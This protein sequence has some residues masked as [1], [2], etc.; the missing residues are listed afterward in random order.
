MRYRAYEHTH[1]PDIVNDVFDSKVYRSLL[2]KPVVV[3]GKE[4]PHKHFADARDV[5]LG[6]STDGFAPFRRRKKTCWPLIL[7]NYNLPP[8]IRF[9][10]HNI[11]SLGVIPGPK[12]PIDLDS[13]LWPAVIEFLRLEL[14]VHAYDILSDE[15]FILRA[16]LI[17]VFGDIPA[18]SLVMQM[19]GH[20]GFRP[21]RM[22]NIHGVRIP[23]ARQPTH[24]VPLDRSQYPASANRANYDPSRLPCRTHDEFLQQANEVQFAPTEAAADRLAQ[25]YGIK[26]TPLLTALSSLSFPDS[27]PYDFMHLVWENVAKNM[28][29]LWSGDFKGLDTGRESYQFE[30]NT[31]KAIGKASA[32]SGSTIPSALGP[33]T[34]DVAAEKMSWTADSRSFW[35]LYVGPVVL[36]RHFTRPKYYK[37][38]TDLVKLLH[39]CLQFELTRQEIANIRTGFITWVKEYEMYVLAPCHTVYTLT[40]YAM[41]SIYY[42]HDPSRLATCPLTVHALLHIADSIEAAGPVWASWAFP[43]ERY[44]GSLQPAIRSRRFP[45]ASINRYLVDHTRLQLIKLMYNVGQELNM[46]GANKAETTVRSERHVANCKFF[47]EPYG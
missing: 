47:Q 15:F 16:F 40:Y 32:Q 31:W 26:G 33:R 4:M 24:Y 29:L 27:F 36:E 14:G 11:L 12:K 23:H 45:Y 39:S 21:C 38:Y 9:H 7:F 5:A 28:M 44:C 1:S 17:L 6:L 3:D 22:C 25:D 35:F 13:F 19:K 30:K 43:M 34:P 10:I 42:Q 20:N 46:K 37:H 2:D 41:L 18:I 8:E